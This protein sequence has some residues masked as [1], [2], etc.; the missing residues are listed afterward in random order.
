MGPGGRRGKDRLVGRPL[1]S[2]HEGP[3]VG[4]SGVALGSH[5]EHR[6]PGHGLCPHF[7]AV[8]A[9]GL[10]GEGRVVEVEVAVGGVE[11][12]GPDSLPRPG[13]ARNRHPGR[14]VLAADARSAASRRPHPVA[15]GESEIGHDPVLGPDRPRFPS[16]SVEVLEAG[17]DGQRVPS[18]R[19]DARGDSLECHHAIHE[20]PGGPAIPD[21]HNR[22][23]S[24]LGLNVLDVLDPLGLK[25][26]AGGRGAD[27]EGGAGDGRLASEGPEDRV[28]VVAGDGC[29]RRRDGEG[30][31]VRVA[32]HGGV[33][34]GGHRQ[35][36]S[37]D[38]LDDRVLHVSGAVVELDEA[39]VGKKDA[40]HIAREGEGVGARRYR[41]R[42]RE[43]AASLPGSHILLAPEIVNEKI[44]QIVHH[45]TEGVGLH[46]EPLK[47]ADDGIPV[48][49]VG[50]VEVAVVGDVCVLGAHPQDVR[51]VHRVEIELHVAAVQRAVLDGG[52]MDLVEMDELLA[53]SGDVP[54]GVLVSGGRLGDAM[55]G[56]ALHVEPEGGR[57][58]GLCVHHEKRGSGAEIEGDV[59]R[60]VGPAALPRIGRRRRDRFQEIF[61][62]VGGRELEDGRGVG[63]VH[64]NAVGAALDPRPLDVPAERRFREGVGHEV[65]S[66]LEGDAGIARG[67]GERLLKG[68]RA[69][70][71]AVGDGAEPFGED[72]SRTGVVSDDGPGAAE[73]LPW[74][75]LDG[76]VYGQCFRRSHFKN[77][78]WSKIKNNC[79]WNCNICIYCSCCINK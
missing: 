10:A 32:G 25:D 17:D 8:P 39:E 21:K 60:H 36:V 33:A 53:V 61:R 4:A 3:D 78:P 74:A 35:A 52:L 76:A 6:S 19:E 49:P 27:T 23:A 18:V 66:A 65:D 55:D 40:A 41:R 63:R 22:S 34:V 7:H 29:S 71:H 1:G 50:A 15:G 69:V 14:P 77:S 73:D 72:R 44:R 56:A 64:G 48:G 57:T 51:V 47:H 16:L 12:P 54:G 11:S 70:R 68:R 26:H 13:F 2:Q 58:R 45:G 79:R 28:A 37:R 67:E 31:V 42:L 59:L 46:L 75:S 62:G 20:S 24:V 43:H 5:V 30:V 38:R 9:R